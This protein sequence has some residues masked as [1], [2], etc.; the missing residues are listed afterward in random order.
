[1]ASIQDAVAADL[2]EYRAVEPSRVPQEF[3]GRVRANPVIRCPLPPFGADP[4]VLRQF[5]TGSQIP[6]IRL[7]PLLPT[8]S[9]ATTKTAAAAT[10]SVASSSSSSSSV[11]SDLV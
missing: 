1:M 5:E 3:D 4:D 8:F 6:H 2:S 7:F 10:S 11:S 9:A